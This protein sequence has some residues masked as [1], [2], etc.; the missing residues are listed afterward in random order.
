M[1]AGRR[2]RAHQ[3][4]RQRFVQDIAHQRGLARAADAGDAD[5]LPER[6]RNVNTLEVVRARPDDFQRLAVSCPPHLRDR[7]LFAPRQVRAGQRPG[8]CEDLLRRAFRDDA[9]AVFARGRP[10]VHHPVRGQDRVGVVFDD[11]HG[12]AEVAQSLERVEQAVV[13]ARMQS[14]GGFVQNVEHAHQ[15]RTHLGGE[16]DALGLPPRKCGGGAAEGQVVESHV[17]QK[18]EPL[19]DFF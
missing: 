10:E 8:V 13:V 9:P 14:N 2:A 7:D 3:F 6:D 15:A 19:D 5:Q 16:S 4:F 11:Q 12:V 18:V 17:H 1:F